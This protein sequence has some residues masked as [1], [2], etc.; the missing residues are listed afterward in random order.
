MQGNVGDSRAVASVHGEVEQLSFDHKPSNES[1]T[2]RIIAAGG[3]VEFNRV[4]GEK[5]FLM[6]H[7]DCEVKFNSFRGELCF[8]YHILIVG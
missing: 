1:E 8:R 2:R 6:S 7:F 3:W 5:H 4:N